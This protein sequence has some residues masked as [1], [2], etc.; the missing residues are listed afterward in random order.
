M[1][2]THVQIAG[3]GTINFRSGALKLGFMP[4]PKKQQMIDIVTPFRITGTFNNPKVHL[5]GG[6][7]GGR[8]IAEV[9]ASPFNLIGQLFTGNKPKSKKEKPCVL[10]KRT[11]PK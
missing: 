5:E 2:G 7:K 10:P 4:R 1:V 3:G 11:K 9:V 8:V 6:G